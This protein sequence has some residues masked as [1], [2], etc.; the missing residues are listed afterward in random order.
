MVCYWVPCL[1]LKWV[2]HPPGFLHLIGRLVSLARSDGWKTGFSR[3]V[4]HHAGERSGF[5]TPAGGGLSY[6]VRHC[7]VNR[8]LFARPVGCC[9]RWLGT[10]VQPRQSGI[11]HLASGIWHLLRFG[12]LGTP[13]TWASNR[14][15]SE[16]SII[17]RS[18]SWRGRQG[19]S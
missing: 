5:V 9:Q 17:L 10:W 16:I 1:I 4:R 11:W 6:L 7:P 8:S 18:V 13:R 15:S 12:D 14:I 3:S 2:R 19:V